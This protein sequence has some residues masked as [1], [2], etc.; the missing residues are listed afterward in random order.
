MR[1]QWDK[2]EKEP[3]LEEQEDQI[4]LRQAQTFAC[5]TL[6]FRYLSPGSLSVP[7]GT[8]IGRCLLGVPVARESLRLLRLCHAPLWNGGH[9]LW[10][11]LDTRG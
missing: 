1:G 11:V 2:E 7:N 9:W 3:V 6:S 10:V 4:R 8:S 5:L